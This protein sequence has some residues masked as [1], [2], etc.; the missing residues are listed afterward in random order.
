MADNLGFYSLNVRGLQCQKKMK[1]VFEWLKQYKNS[2]ILLQETHSSK[3]IE[4]IWASQWNGSIYYSHGTTAAAGVCILLPNTFD[5]QEKVLYSD[6][7][8]RIIALEIKVNDVNFVV[9]NVYAPTKNHENAQ[10]AFL[11][12]LE[13][14]LSQTQHLILG[15]DWNT[16]LDKD[17]DK[18][19][20][21]TEITNRKYHSKLQAIMEIYDLTDCWR[22]YHP[23]KRKFT[24][25]QHKPSVQC[26]LDFWLISS[27][28]LNIIDHTQIK[29]GFRSDH[30]LIKLILK[31][32]NIQKGWGLWKFNCS[33]LHDTDYVN[34]IKNLIET[35]IEATETMVD[36]GF[37]WDYVKMRIRSETVLYT[38]TKRKTES[39][40][41]F[42]LNNKL[43][44]LTSQ[45]TD[46]PTDTL[47]ESIAQ[48][49]Q[50][51][52][53]LTQIKVN[54]AMLRSKCE[55]T[56]NGEKNTQFF[57][58]LERKHSE[59]K[60][61]CQLEKDNT[62][63]RNQKEIENE[64][65]DYYKKLYSDV[66]IREDLL[67]DL[68]LPFSKLNEEDLAL[69]EG[70]ISE[71]ECL[72]ALKSMQNGKTP[73]LD[74]LPADFY[75]FFWHDIKTLVLNSL[76]YAF[77]T[78]RMSQDQRIGIITLIPKKDK[79]RTI[80]KNW[81]P[82]SLLTVDYKLIAKCLAKRLEKVLPKIVSQSQYA[83]IK[84]CYIGENVRA[85]SDINDYLKNK[86][87]TGIILQID[88][89]KAFDSVNWK[90][91]D[92]VLN[93]F[94]FGETFKKWVKIMYS[95]I[96]SAV[97]NN[98]NITKF[99]SLY[100]GV[101][102]GCP[103]SAILFILIAETLA[104]ILNNRPDIR[105]IKIE[106][107]EV[108]ILQFADDTNILIE[109]KESIPKVL[110]V[111]KF[112]HKISGLKINVDK[113]IAFQ[114]GINQQN[115]AG[116]TY[117]LNWVNDNI[118][119]LG[120]TLVDD[121][122][123]NYTLNF[124]KRIQSIKSLTQIWSQRSLS[125]KGKITVINSLLIPKLL[126]P[127]T[128]VCI[129]NKVYD[130]VDSLLFKFLWD[131]K[132][133]K[134]RKNVIIRMIEEGGLKMPDFRTKV[135]SWKCLWVKR[136]DYGIN[137]NSLWMTIMNALFPKHC[138]IFLVCKSRVSNNFLESLEDVPKFYK[139]ILSIWAELKNFSPVE[140]SKDILNECIWA[141]KYITIENKSIVWKKWID[142]N[143][144]YVYD[145]LNDENSFKTPQQFLSECNLKTNF[146]EVLQIKQA[147]PGHWRAS[148]RETNFNKETI[149]RKIF[150]KL[151]DRSRPIQKIK[152]KELYQTLLQKLSDA[153][154]KPAGQLKWENE[155]NIPADSFKSIY[156]LPFSCCS[157]TKYQSFQYKI[158]HRIIACNHWLFK[159]NIH[160]TGLC[161]FCDKDDTLQ[162][163]FIHC[164][165]TL[166]FWKS[167]YNWWNNLNVF[168]IPGPDIKK[169]LFGYLELNK[170]LSAINYM[171]LIAKY[172]IYKQKQAT[173]QPF[174]PQFL[175]ELKNQLN[176]DEMISIKNNNHLQ[177]IDK[178]DLIY[179]SL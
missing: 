49:Q 44:K 120:L 179:S 73:G 148:L 67:T 55:W 149:N 169:I 53:R 106:N 78:D 113:T 46:T 75:Y 35:E 93:N 65:Y 142:K 37:R 58:N 102:Q 14:C 111:L 16:I 29:P 17:I 115:F 166:I 9:C 141:N 39:R 174:F 32:S 98:G 151:N 94:G 168:R 154:A 152:S 100:K 56:E 110:K 87:Q 150:V 26:R 176:I 72:E 105:G 61:I 10:L 101:R 41:E 54:G 36:K 69:T 45:Y 31:L 74:G 59:N 19:G 164:P 5:F 28:L 71:K 161:S 4:K 108:K 136:I 85:V 76:N 12:E 119:L 51:L 27:E 64:I 52:E 171:L 118:T 21:L 47:Y 68:D 13:N 125:L 11:H 158:I 82:I 103:L 162:H 117:G 34:K 92:F 178:Y 173:L 172:H 160:L 38:S 20:G 177:F 91:M 167:F 63:L 159:M 126:Y 22:I 133:A 155:L 2:I 134:I 62:T 8:G 156:K 25:F 114:I 153:Q 79:V 145:L 60:L 42:D 121:E 83:Y 132:P 139:D 104:L 43:E 86:K 97:L 128:N 143:I 84:D 130:E 170:F 123:E 24:W 140:N 40:E 66:P 96:S 129:P 90:F 116:R 57:L 81:R 135:K 137:K 124:Y 50:E 122:N 6:I 30:S 89:E 175:L 70:A 23:N 15:G 163:H 3:D 33:L 131:N 99:F 1:S 77:A 112:F 88:F 127:S 95:D 109:N 147:L 144:M 165:Q 7:N 146:L 80:L 18:K 138:S 48:V 157:F 107:N